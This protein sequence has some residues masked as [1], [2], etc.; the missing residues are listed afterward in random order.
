MLKQKIADAKDKRH[1]QVIKL[2]IAFTGVTLIC[3]GVLFFLSCC[4]INFKNEDSMFPE[5]TSNAEVDTINIV[6]PVPIPSDSKYVSI[7][8][9]SIVPS[10]ADEKLRLSYISMLNEYESSI[11]LQIDKIDLNKW[12]KPRS[13]RLSIFANDALTKFSLADYAGAASAIN[14][15]LQ[16]AES[17]ILDSQKEFSASLS[18]AQNSYANDNYDEA[19]YQVD[20]ALM[21]DNSSSEAK[22]LSSDIDM[23]QE[24]LPL[25]DKMKIARV[26][27]NHEKELG[28][29]KE[30]IKLVPGRKKAVERK[31]ELINI[32]SKK[33]FNK[34]ISLSYAAIKLSDAVKAKKKLDAARKIFSQRQEI[35][36]VTIALEELEKELKLKEYLQ[37]AES[38]VA[39]D[40]WVVA[41]QQ[42]EL[43]LQERKDDKLIQK[44]LSGATTIIQLKTDFDK[45][46]TN[47]Y[48]LSNKNLVAKANSQI[49][50]ANDYAVISPSLHK[51]TTDL[52]NLINKM[53]KEISVEVTSDN[54][55]NILVR[56]VGVVGLT[57]SKIIQLTPGR[58][59]F[60]GKRSGYK[61]KLL[62]VLI[63]YDKSTYQI[64]I[65]CDE[66]I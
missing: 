18:S 47:P 59:K 34:N 45:Y 13:D 46:L 12:D 6:N 43:A 21:L 50:Q 53:S 11:K 58:Y 32:I 44:S 64:T 65:V 4:E 62:E 42:L 14:K 61:S 54:Q 63:P 51:K 22:N 52:T 40:N 15:L 1:K 66:S 3:G 29:I 31:K 8:K 48:R 56:G 9:E 19:K 39:A 36:D 60:E 24:L 35:T 27:N 10:E 28:I 30:I 57:Q 20:N 16:H 55:T 25:L 17:I 33:N 23:L 49:S 41:K 38:A 7:P 2:T 5:L 26:E 37:L